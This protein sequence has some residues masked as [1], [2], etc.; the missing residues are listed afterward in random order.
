M[1]DSSRSARSGPVVALIVAALLLSGCGDD[2]DAGPAQPSTEQTEGDGAGEDAGSNDDG[3]SSG[4]FDDLMYDATDS[5]YEIDGTAFTV[6]TIIRCDPFSSIGEPDPG[7]LDLQALSEDRTNLRLMYTPP[8]EE[9]AETLR[10]QGAPDDYI[11]QFTGA[12][13]SVEFD[14]GSTQDMFGVPY[15]NGDTEFRSS[16]V[17]DDRMTGAATITDDETGQVVEVTWD[18]EVPP[19]AH[20]CSL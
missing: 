16:E 10:Q 15:I 17:T 1:R 7:Q 5:S 11:E 4:R 13:T 12:S 2:D 9:Q 8:D 3:S 18:V 6:T 14:G 19:E 20:D